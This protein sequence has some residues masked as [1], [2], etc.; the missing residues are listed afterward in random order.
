L[1]VEVDGV[2]F[3]LSALVREISCIQAHCRM[4]FRSCYTRV[5]FCALNEGKPMRIPMILTCR[6]VIARGFPLHSP[7]HA[8][9]EVRTR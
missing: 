7:V 3:S 9:T 4:L 5:A 1:L 6:D 2:V 8:K